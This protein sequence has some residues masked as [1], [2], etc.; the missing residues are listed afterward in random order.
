MLKAFQKLT[1]APEVYNVM[2]GPSEF[3]VMGKLKNWDITSR[4]HEI[5]LPTLILSGRFDESTPAINKT[6]HDGIR[7]SEQIIFENSSHFPHVEETASFMKT[8]QD[9]LHRHDHT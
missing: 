4:L 6:L 9:F 1:E 5:I 3:Y 2:N 7:G 8:V